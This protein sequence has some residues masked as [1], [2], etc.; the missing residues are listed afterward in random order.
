MST[1]RSDVRARAFLK[2][3]YFDP[4]DVLGRWRRLQ[5][6]G[7]QSDLPERVRNLRTRE[8]KKLSEMRQGL[9][10]CLGMSER[11]G[12]PVGFAQSEEADYDG[13]AYWSVDEVAHFSPIQLKEVPPET[14]NP[15]ASVQTILDGLA[16]YAD[17]EELS[18]AIY[19]N[20][21]GSVN[22]SELHLPNVKFGGIW[23]FAAANP[24]Q[25]EW[26]LYGDLQDAL[27]TETRYRH[28]DP[29]AT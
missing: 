12:L 4:V 3:K 10:F 24:E 6:E 26:V 23:M 15:T 5:I 8:L 19:V 17:S 16:Q 22:L 18:V 28:P 7:A 9:L 1:T 2:L 20:R 29:P 11:L 27:R 13:V 25:T 21:D 14:L